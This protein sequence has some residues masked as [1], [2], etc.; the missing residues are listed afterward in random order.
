MTDQPSGTGPDD[1]VKEPLQPLYFQPISN[2]GHSASYEALVEVAQAPG[3]PVF[4]VTVT[5]ASSVLSQAEKEVLD[6]LDRMKAEFV[7]LPGPPPDNSSGDEE[8]FDINEQL[9]IEIGLASYDGT[10]PVSVA[11]T[12]E[13]VT[14]VVPLPTGSDPV[15]GTKVRRDLPRTLG[16]DLD[17]YWRAKPYQPFTATVEITMGAG[18]VRKPKQSVD[19][20][21]TYFATGKQVIVH[22]GRIFHELLPA[23]RLRPRSPWRAGQLTARAGRLTRSLSIPERPQSKPLQ[24]SACSTTLAS[25]QRSCT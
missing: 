25:R 20:V 12:V 6:L 2:D 9:L 3:S 8:A 11:V 19:A 15:G 1:P 22:A 14:G 16:A 10:G 13:T 5:L 4:S 17:D 7:V 18:T 24:F 23:R 21:N